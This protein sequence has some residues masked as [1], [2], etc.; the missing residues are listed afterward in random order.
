M[1]RTWSTRRPLS[2]IQQAKYLGAY[3]IYRQ[4]T[5]QLSYMKMTLKATTVERTVVTVSHPETSN[6]YYSTANNNLPEEIQKMLTEYAPRA[7][8]LRPKTFRWYFVSQV[9]MNLL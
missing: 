8:T 5:V 1:R 9:H 3:W 2:P 7:K 4:S 6:W